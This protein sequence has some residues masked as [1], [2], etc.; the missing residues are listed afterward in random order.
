FL[1]CAPGH[2]N[3]NRSHAAR[4]YRW[5]SLGKPAGLACKRRAAPPSALS[6]QATLRCSPMA[7][8]AQA[9]LRCESWDWRIVLPPNGVFPQWV[10][11][12]ILTA[13]G[14]VRIGILTHDSSRLGVRQDWNPNP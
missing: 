3:T 5:R 7:A 4:G 6:C 10:R 8:T 11:I 13:W 14:F 2:G 1:E 9:A 12:P